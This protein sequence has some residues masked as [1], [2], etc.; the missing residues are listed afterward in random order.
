MGL[1]GKKGRLPPLLGMPMATWQAYAWDRDS[2]SASGSPCTMLRCCRCRMQSIAL[3]PE[4]PGSLKSMEV[5]Q[6]PGY[7]DGAKSNHLLLSHNIAAIVGA[8]RF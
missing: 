3:L 4:R 2:E 7:E 8:D 1:E 5:A 6:T